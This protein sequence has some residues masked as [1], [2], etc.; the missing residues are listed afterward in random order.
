[1]TMDHR[2]SPYTQETPRWL[3]QRFTNGPGDRHDRYSDRITALIA[4]DVLWDPEVTLHRDERAAA[5]ALV[6]D[7]FDVYFTDAEPEVPDRV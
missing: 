7:V 4:L 5:E 1:M 2:T 6:A 3:W